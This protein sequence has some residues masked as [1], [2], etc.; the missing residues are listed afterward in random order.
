MFDIKKTENKFTEAHQRF[1]QDLGTIQT[2]RASIAIL[3]NV[4]VDS[5]GTKTP[6]N[7]IASIKVEDPKCL[8]ISPWDKSQIPAIE[9]SIA[10]ADLGVSSASDGDGVRVLIPD[11]TTDRRQQ[12]AKTAEKKM[13]E[14]KIRVRQ[15]REDAMNEIKKLEL[16]DDEKKI[17]QDQVQEQVKKANLDLESSTKIKKEE[18][19]NI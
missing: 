18:I 9:K 5:Y 6:L 10:L 1:I 2:G 11:M 17:Y 14:G 16:S 19:L 15:I 4:M 3:D 8:R 7:Q 13:E 12:I